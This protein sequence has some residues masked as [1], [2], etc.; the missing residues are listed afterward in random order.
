MGRPDNLVSAVSRVYLIRKTL[1]AGHGNHVQFSVTIPPRLA[2]PFIAEYGHEFRWEPQKD[3]LLMK[4]ISCDESTVLPP[5][6]E[7]NGAETE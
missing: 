4:P 5:W 6:L 2:E 7:S 3:G 1:G